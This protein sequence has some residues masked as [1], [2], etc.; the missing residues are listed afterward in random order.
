ML[1][2]RTRS[3]VAAACTMLAVGLTGCVTLGEP[4]SAEEESETAPPE[5]SPEVSQEAADPGDDDAQD[6]VDDAADDERHNGPDD[7]PEGRPDEDLDEDAE[8]EDAEGEDEEEDSEAE[9][10]EDP[11][12]EPESDGGAEP[13]GPAGSR[14]DPFSVGDSFGYGDWEVTINGVTPEADDLIA[15]ENQFN[16]PAPEGTSYLLIDASVTYE[17]ADSEM[18]MMGVDFAYVSDSG[19]TYSSYDTIA[20]P[21]DELDTWQE[22]YTGGTAEGNIAIAVPD[23]GQGLIRARV[24]FFDTQDGFFALG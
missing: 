12:D 10:D 1:S 11:D 17:G 22:L 13:D 21:P 24:G 4:R 15:A 6:Q 2:R 19:E 20:I 9:A 7:E 14:D 5:T 8:G 23:D 16:D 18:I 3:G